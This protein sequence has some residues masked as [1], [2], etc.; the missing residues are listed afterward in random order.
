MT[1]IHMKKIP[2]FPFRRAVSDDSSTDASA[3]A[4]ADYI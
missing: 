4:A 3:A 1:C 2:F